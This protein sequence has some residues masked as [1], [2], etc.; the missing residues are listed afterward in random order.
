M[1][2]SA[3]SWTLYNVSQLTNRFLRLPLMTRC[4][5]LSARLCVSV[6]PAER[7]LVPLLHPTTRNDGG[8]A[9]HRHTTSLRRLNRSD[10]RP[11]ATD[12]SQH[13]LSASR[14]FVWA[15]SEVSK[16]RITAPNWCGGWS[17][18]QVTWNIQKRKRKKEKVCRFYRSDNTPLENAVGCL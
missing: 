15:L 14:L 11:P 13:T 6:T 3:P 4:V 9:A 10:R 1:D 2:R 18:G 5:S 17:D 16:Q 7:N 8:A 12:I